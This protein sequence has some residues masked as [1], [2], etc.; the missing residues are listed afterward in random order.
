MGNTIYPVAFHWTRAR[1]LGGLL[2]SLC[3]DTLAA[4]SGVKWGGA[5]WALTL[6]PGG[7]IL[8]LKQILKRIHRDFPVRHVRPQPPNLISLG[9]P[10][11]AN[12]DITCLFSSVCFVT[13][14]KHPAS[15]RYVATLE[16][17]GTPVARPTS[18]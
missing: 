15:F 13:E 6:P 11:Q 7:F 4:S 12:S 10:S 2:G 1:D 5:V 18:Q 14:K 3:E 16:G 8:L 9:G 17:K